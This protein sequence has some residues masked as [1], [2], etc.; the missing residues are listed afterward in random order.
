MKGIKFT[1]REKQKALELWSKC[2]DYFY[3]AKKSK[4]TVQSLYRW[5]RQFDGTLASLDNKSSRPHTPHPNAHTEAEAANIAAVFAERPDISYAE[6]LGVLR[7]Q[8]G[9]SRTYGGFY[10]YLMKHKLRPAREYDGYIPQPY[11]TP[12][13]LG[14]KWQMDVKYV[15]RECYKGVVSCDEKRTR[16]FQYTM[17]DEATRERFIYPYTEQTATATKNFIQRAIVYFGYIPDCI[18]TDNGGEFTN[19]RGAG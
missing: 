5:R 18:Q 13:M 14:V 19:P 17:I 6:A 2:G 9:Y 7:T 16:F 12:T 8:Y 4:C 3:A 10:R 15:P 1:A 11:D